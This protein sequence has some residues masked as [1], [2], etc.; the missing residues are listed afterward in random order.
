MANEYKLPSSMSLDA[1]VKLKFY[2]FEICTMFDGIGPMDDL[3]FCTG[4]VGANG[5]LLYIQ[6]S[7]FHIMTTLKYF[8]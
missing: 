3:D 7:P 8:F 5:T 2:D 4:M 1:Y 6:N